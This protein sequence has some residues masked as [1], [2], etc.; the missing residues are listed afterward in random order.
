MRETE[1]LDVAPIDA[2]HSMSTKF[3]NALPIPDELK[4]RVLDVEVHWS[5]RRS[6]H[7]RWTQLK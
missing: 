1:I 5:L 7:E 4:A 6:V 3:V 2:L